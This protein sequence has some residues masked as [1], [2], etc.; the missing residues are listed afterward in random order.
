[1]RHEDMFSKSGFPSNNDWSDGI[2]ADC[3]YCNII[4]EICTET[5]MTVRM[6]SE[7]QNKICPFITK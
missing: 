6:G 3:P 5:G 1:M 4:E 2:C 7:R